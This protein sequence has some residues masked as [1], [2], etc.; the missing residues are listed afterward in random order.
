M[1]PRRTGPPDDAPL[2]LDD[3]VVL[4]K[5]FLDVLDGKQQEVT[6]LQSDFKALQADNWRLIAKAERDK[7]P[8]IWK[9][10]RFAIRAAS[11]DIWVR[12]GIFVP[13][14]QNNEHARQRQRETDEER[15]R[16]WCELGIIVA[17]KRGGRWFVRMD[18]F[19]AY[20]AGLRE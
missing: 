2:D 6:R 1:K 5:F 4:R 18:S 16:K 7:P 20:L 11:V 15:V 14:A 3:I 19:N 17:E 10:I 12:Q 9:S 8:E 13:P